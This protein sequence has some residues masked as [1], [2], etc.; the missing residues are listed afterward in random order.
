MSR[1]PRLSLSLSLVALAA[2]LGVRALAGPSSPQVPG[3]DPLPAA[4]SR[5]ADD[6]SPGPL[7]PSAPASL[8]I[9]ERLALG[10]PVTEGLV[11]LYP[12]VDGQAAARP[13]GEYQLL[14]DGLEAG[15]FTV[16]ESDGGTVPTLM[17]RNRGT[18]PVLL[19]AGDVVKG[20]KQDRVVTQDFVVQP[21]GEPVDVA[22]NCVEHGRWSAGATGHSFGYGGRG[23]GSLKKVV[24]VAKNQ[25]ATWSEV[26]TSNGRKADVVRSKGAERDAALLAPETGTYVASLENPAVRDEVEPATKALVG[27]L[28]AQDHV[29]GVVVA[30]GGSITTAELFGHPG[31]F[32][33]S[34]DDLVRS[35]VLDGVGA[36][37]TGPA[38]DGAAAAAFLR[39]A[40]Q[41]SVVTADEAGV[42]NKAEKASA[43]AD[44][45]ETTSKDGERIHFNAYAK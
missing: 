10:A 21:N 15:T 8:A 44:A 9:D 11:T 7:A 13:A 36:E 17:V 18:L 27:K 6:L 23:E 22:V 39:D 2:L 29:V 3:A 28:A 42:A 34:R 30:V 32:A 5:A 43:A 4:A 35:F 45:F 40:L 1:S 14:R 12:V 33:R 37:A 24:Q 16:E 41:A 25:S 26:A 20:G 19:V 38:P 31:L